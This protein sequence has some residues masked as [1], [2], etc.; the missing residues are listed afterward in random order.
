MKTSK[1]KK[2]N[3]KK[4]EGCCESHITLPHPDH[5]LYLPRLKRVEGQ[6]AGIQKMI[7]EGRY[8]VDILIQFRASMAALRSIEVAIFEK[9]LQH[10]LSTALH[11]QNKKQIDEKINEL[12]DLLSR[13]TSL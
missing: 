6:I 1:A 7:Q 8:C 11:S 5:S 3:S 12:T 4:A 10:C 2:T 9:H 13:R